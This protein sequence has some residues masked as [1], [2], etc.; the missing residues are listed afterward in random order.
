MNGGQLFSINH[1]ENNTQSCDIT[2][3]TTHTHIHVNTYDLLLP[4]YPSLNGDKLSHKTQE[5][6]TIIKERDKIK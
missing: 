3:P 6:G 4:P 2:Q 1:P 5:Q